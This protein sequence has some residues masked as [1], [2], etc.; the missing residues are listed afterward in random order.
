MKIL[1]IL[2]LVFLTGCASTPYPKKDGKVVFDSAG[3]CYRLRSYDI[4]NAKEVYYLD[5]LEIQMQVGAQL[6]Q[7]SFK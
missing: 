1:L 2:I 6:K 4:F 3:T 5:K 7:E